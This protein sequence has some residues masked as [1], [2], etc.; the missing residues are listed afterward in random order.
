M[1]T[2]VRT[3]TYRYNEE[4]SDN[5]ERP[6]ACTRTTRDLKFLALIVRTLIF[7]SL[8]SLLGPEEPGRNDPHESLGRPLHGAAA[9]HRRGWR[10]S[11]E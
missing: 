9:L 7:F 3:V 6:C 11:G 2:R 5:H 1:T 4:L 10:C 8:Q